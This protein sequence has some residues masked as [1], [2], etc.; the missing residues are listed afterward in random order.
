MYTYQWFVGST[1][2]S[3]TPN[4]SY[5]FNSIG[6][7]LVTVRSRSIETGCEFECSQSITV[8]SMPVVSLGSNLYKCAS[9]NTTLTPTVTGGSGVGLLINGAVEE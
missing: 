3:T 4:L 6:N 5:Q 8:Y 2:V 1:L 7:Y 9:V